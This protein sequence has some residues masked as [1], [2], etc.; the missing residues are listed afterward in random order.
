MQGVYVTTYIDNHKWM[1]HVLAST[2]VAT[3][4]DD[5]VKENKE[6]KMEFIVDMAV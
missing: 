1:I 3:K 2:Y 5:N 4:I 6:L